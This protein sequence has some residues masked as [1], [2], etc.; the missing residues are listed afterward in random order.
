MSEF[1]DWFTELD[2][3]NWSYL[4]MCEMLGSLAFAAYFYIVASW[5]A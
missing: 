1:W 4:R 3:G 5:P 2:E